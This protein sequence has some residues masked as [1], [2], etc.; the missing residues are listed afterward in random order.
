MAKKSKTKYIRHD[1]VRLQREFEKYKLKNSEA[2]VKEFC[3]LKGLDYSNA[4]AKIKQA[5]AKQKVSIFEAEKNAAFTETLR[6]KKE[7]RAKR[8]LSVTLIK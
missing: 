3:A 1:W 4:R 5:K 6:K 8:K 7:K 2:T